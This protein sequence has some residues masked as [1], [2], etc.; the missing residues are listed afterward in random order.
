VVAYL[1][2]PAVIIFACPVRD[3]ARLECK[4]PEVLGAQSSYSCQFAESVDVPSSPS[5]FATTKIHEHG[6]IPLALKRKHL[7]LVFAYCELI[8]INSQTYTTRD[9]CGQECAACCPL[10]TR[11]LDVPSPFPGTSPRTPA[12]HNGVCGKTLKWGTWAP[13]SVLIFG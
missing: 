13:K 8:D 11:S 10:A 6:L 2:A 12:S 7:I 4:P 5:I 1:L 3:N 9:T